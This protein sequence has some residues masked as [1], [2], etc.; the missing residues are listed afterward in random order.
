MYAPTLAIDHVSPTTA[1]K[2]LD[3]FKE[4]A[5]KWP[6]LTAAQIRD[7]RYRMA[8]ALEHGQPIVLT[9]HEA[10]ALVTM[11]STYQGSHVDP[12]PGDGGAVARLMNL[13]RGQ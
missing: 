13:G 7:M 5:E 3:I 1:A 12:L 10:T 4:E 9:A 8:Y 2:Y 11:A 6:P